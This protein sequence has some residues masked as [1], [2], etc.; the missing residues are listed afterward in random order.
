MHGEPKRH[1]LVS[2]R[3]VHSALSFGLSKLKPAHVSLTVLNYL[4]MGMGQTIIRHDCV[5]R[6]MGSLFLH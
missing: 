1:R 6:E 3:V 5:Q 2:H 4:Q